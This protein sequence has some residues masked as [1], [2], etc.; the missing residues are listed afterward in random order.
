MNVLQR[1]MRLLSVL[2]LMTNVGPII[3][4]EQ[5]GNRLKEK[6]KQYPYTAVLFVKSDK[7]DDKK[8]DTPAAKTAKLFL[9]ST[10]Q[11]LYKDAGLV[12]VIVDTEGKSLEDFS[13]EV[14]IQFTQLPTVVLYEEGNP[15]KKGKKVA[16]LVNPT[17]KQQVIDFINDRLEDNLKEEADKVKKYARESG[18]EEEVD[19][20][21]VVNNYYYYNYEGDTYETYNPG[22]YWPFFWPWGWTWGGGFFWGGGWGAW[23]NY[24]YHGYG[25]GYGHGGGHGG[26][27]GRGGR[28]GHGGRGGSRRSGRSGSSRS[29]RTSRSSSSS[30]RSSSRSGGSRGGRGG[31]FRGGRGGGHG[32]GHGGRR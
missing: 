18:G 31:G 32:G 26:H 8:A 19:E 27:G 12:F 25:R 7:K 14:G 17:T 13:S 11:S 1:A 28:G 24:H 15:V 2:I 9:E 21:T 20:K 16:Q 30:R 29:S 5:E 4:T 3:A 10:T 23:G 22:L 6:I